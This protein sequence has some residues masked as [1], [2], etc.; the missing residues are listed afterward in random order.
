MGVVKIKLVKRN[1][2]KRKGRGKGSSFERTICRELSLWWTKGKR[3]DIF[4]RTS[5][6]GGRA[7]IRSKKGKK[8]FGQYG[9]IQAVDPKG[10]PLIDL[11]TIEAK[12]GSNKITCAD[13]IDQPETYSRKDKQTRLRPTPW[14][15]F[16]TQAER[17]AKAAGTRFWILI[18]KRDRRNTVIFLPFPL[19]GLLCSYGSSILRS[20]PRCSVIIEKRYVLGIPLE[21]FTSRVCP[22]HIRKAAKEKVRMV[23]VRKK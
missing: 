12:R 15:G 4:W 22:K 21:E 7:T 10:Q 18:H 1:K 11:C 9:D 19:V 3:D 17:Q 13:I 2:A 14:E 23:I 8:T 16:I 5:Q 20:D 6:S